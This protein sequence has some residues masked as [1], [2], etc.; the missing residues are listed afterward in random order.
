MI[1]AA[2][3]LNVVLNDPRHDVSCME[4]VCVCVCV[5]EGERDG[6]YHDHIWYGVHRLGICIQIMMRL[7]AVADLGG[8][9]GYD[10]PPFLAKFKI[11]CYTKPTV[12]GKLCTSW[13]PPCLL[14]IIPQL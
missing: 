11:G 10:R 9:K 6:G 8:F 12:V 4:S 1:V 14:A 13:N 5:C 2:L 3:L 7:H